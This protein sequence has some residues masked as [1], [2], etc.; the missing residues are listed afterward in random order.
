MDI[1][2]MSVD[3]QVQ[4]SLAVFPFRIS[5]S[6]SMRKYLSKQQGIGRTTIAQ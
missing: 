5:N 6:T 1:R 3:A 4:Q 2:H